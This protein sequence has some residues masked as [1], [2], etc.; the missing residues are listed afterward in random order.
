M[1][2]C[3]CVCVCVCISLLVVNY[4][5]SAVFATEAVW[6]V[7]P[8]HVRFHLVV[9]CV[10]PS[11]RPSVWLSLLRLS[12]RAVPFQTSN[13]KLQTIGIVNLMRFRYSSV[14]LTSIF[15]LD[16]I[17]PTKGFRVMKRM[18]LIESIQWQ[19]I[20]ISCSV[21]CLSI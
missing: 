20:R 7:A 5:A 1:R 14:S 19:P 3:V 2:V 10:C 11:V 9:D 17:S 4:L 15:R 8:E 6:K 21:N 16:H 13:F 18:K 12:Q